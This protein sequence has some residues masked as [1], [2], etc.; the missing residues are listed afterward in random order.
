MGKKY[1]K[2][3]CAKYFYCYSIKLKD[4]LK[5]R[6]LQYESRRKHPNGLNYW[7]FVKSPRLSEELA[8]WEVYKKIF[9]Q[10]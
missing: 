9:K 3:E 2:E 5:L 1:T 8:M 4:F 10:D 6:G 7:T